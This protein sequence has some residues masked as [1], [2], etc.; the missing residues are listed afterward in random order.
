MEKQIDDIIKSIL[1]DGEELDT[2]KSAIDKLSGDS[3]LYGKCE[4]FV[5]TFRELRQNKQVSNVSTNKLKFQGKQV[6]LKEATVQTLIDVLHGKM[7]QRPKL[8]SKPMAASPRKA[9]NMLAEQGKPSDPSPMVSTPDKPSRFDVKKLWTK[10]SGYLK[11]NWKW[12]AGIAATIIALIVVLSLPSNVHDAESEE[13]E[14]ILS[15]EEQLKKAIESHLELEMVEY[16]FKNVYRTPNDDS[17]WGNRRLLIQYTAYVT[18]G[19][20]LRKLSM[21]DVSI[22]EDQNTITIRL[23]KAEIMGLNI[24]DNSIKPITSVTGWRSNYSTEEIQKVLGIAEK[25]VEKAIPNCGILQDAE[26]FAKAYFELLLG[27]LGY[28]NVRVSFKS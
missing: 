11:T 27:Q 15:R 19:V 6:G 1:L 28:E 10:A 9:D 26:G 8:P 2:Y 14:H 16:T 5:A 22:S 12:V 25:E 13:Q 7:P 18:A 4:K 21:N 24:P 20:D 3:D 17:F 23:P